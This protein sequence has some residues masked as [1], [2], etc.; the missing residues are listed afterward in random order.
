M[1]AFYKYHKKVGLR[2]GLILIITALMFLPRV[3]A[4]NIPES[5]MPVV[6]IIVNES[7][8]VETSEIRLGD[9]AFITAG[10]FLKKELA[11]LDMGSAPKPGKIKIFDQKRIISKIRAKHLVPGNARISA[12]TRVYIKRASQAVDKQVLKKRMDQY[13]EQKLV[14]KEYRVFAFDVRGLEP[15]PSGDV[16]LVFE[17]GNI[18][19][20]NGKICIY[21]DVIIN[22]KKEDRITLLGKIEVFERVVCTSKPLRRGDK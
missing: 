16:N 21:V 13:L 18:Y 8:Q 6:Q 15:Y 5:K 17:N 7:S 3:N 9:I 4:Q 10:D 14:N 22:G 1:T 12:P 2:L 20:E 19:D 11:M